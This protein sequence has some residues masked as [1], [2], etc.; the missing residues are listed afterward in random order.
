MSTKVTKSEL[1]AEVLQLREEVRLLTQ[2]VELIG[3]GI[4][5]PAIKLKPHWPSSAMGFNTF[6]GQAL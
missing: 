5:S 4:S 6:S 1:L 2:Y 3:K